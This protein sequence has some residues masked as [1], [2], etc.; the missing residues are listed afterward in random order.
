MLTY[1]TEDDF[2]QMK[3][4]NKSG[5]ITVSAASSDKIQ[6]YLERAT[7]FIRRFTGRDFFPWVET[8]HFPIPYAYSDL[9]MRRFPAAHLKLDQDLLETFNVNNGVDDLVE[10]T[11]YF[12]LEY[13][14][15][16]KRIIAVKYPYYW[17]GFSGAGISP[18]KRY[19]EAII[20]VDAMWGY[21]DHL[22]PSEAWID[23]FETIPVGGLTSSATTMTLVDVD[24]DDAWNKKKFYLNQ[25]IRVDDELMIVSGINTGTNV[26]TVLRG[27]RGS[28]ATTHDAGVAI[29]R[30]R[31]LED[32]TDACLK[33]AKTWRE[34]DIAAGGRLGVSEM[35]AGTEIS[36]PADP[37]NTLK[38]YR[39]SIR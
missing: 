29:K 31:V 20:E 35:S 12:T 25:L 13:N 32:I 27:Q 23:T 38:M 3:D 21:A 36:I 24:G 28:T 17:G 33:I 9:R 16:P 19:D 37:L 14:I 39:R 15:Y 5:L 2:I 22:Y 26:L 4:V 34:S 7:R 8:R 18:Y 11:Q 6:A 10:T 1:A 30:W